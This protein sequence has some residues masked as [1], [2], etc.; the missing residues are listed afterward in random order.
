MAEAKS[1]QFSRAHGA[2]G[3]QEQNEAVAQVIGEGNMASGC[4]DED[5]QLPTPTLTDLSV[6]LSQLQRL[7]DCECHH[8]WLACSICWT[9]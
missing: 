3:E 9:F 1:S 4:I 2:K 7:R 8:A 5:I 6:T